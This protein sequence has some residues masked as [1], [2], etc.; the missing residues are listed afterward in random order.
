MKGFF[1]RQWDLFLNDMQEIG[2][3]FLDAFGANETLMLGA[4]KSDSACGEN[5]GFFKREWRLFLQDMQDWGEMIMGA[6]EGEDQ[7]LLGTP[8]EVNVEQATQPGFFKRE[9]ELFKTDLDNANATL[10]SLFG[11]EKKMK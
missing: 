9:W 6:F 7:L 8:K 1:E 10:E 5:E 3:F 2:E 4:A 11:I